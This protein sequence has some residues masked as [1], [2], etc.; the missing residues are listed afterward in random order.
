MRAFDYSKLAD[1]TWDGN[2]SAKTVEDGIAVW[3]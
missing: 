3:K 2:R 1:R